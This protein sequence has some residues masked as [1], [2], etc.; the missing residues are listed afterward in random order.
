MIG[1]ETESRVDSF[2]SACERVWAEE[3]IVNGPKYMSRAPARLDVM[4]G[5]A[6]Y[7]GSL[8]LQCALPVE[9][10]VGIAP[11]GDQK[12]SITSIG[13]SNNGA[14][15]QSIWPL[16]ALYTSAGKLASPESFAAYFETSGS[17]W[18]RHVAGVF[19]TLLEAGVVPHFAGGAS[20][21][22]QSDI[23][24]G[25]G[26]GASAAIAVASGWALV[27]LTGRT[28]APIELARLCQRA[29]TF[30]AGVPCGITDK[31]VALLA[32]SGTLLQMRCQPHE[33]LGHMPLCPG[34]A[35][36]GIDSR[37]QAE[38]RCHR[39]IETRVASFMGLRIIESVLR[40]NPSGVDITGGYLAN[41]TPTEYVERLRDRIPTKM[42]G[43]DFLERYGHINDPAT[44]V[45]PDTMYKVRSRTEH[46]IYENDRVHRFAERISRA[47]RTQDRGPLIEAGEL[48]YASH[49]SYSQRCGMGSIDTDTLVN[50][51]REQGVDRGIYGAKI[52]SAG[53]GGSVAVLLADTPT[54]HEAVEQACHAYAMKTGREP[55]IFTGSADGAAGEAPRVLD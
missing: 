41:I 2:A 17:P 22:I 1:T 3:P 19:Y 36:V 20:I 53:C 45:A 54:A 55:E 32:E 6:D 31:A 38:K 46:H 50:L 49:W 33:V 9:A 44:R 12:V 26:I 37:A 24:S 30:V 25:A 11:R 23:P 10:R 52:T 21:V 47:A 5:V 14:G 42:K 48:M 8:V 34:T 27:A 43:R 28:I 29:E 15:A 18:A 4:G 16:S 39:F 35:F 7:T 40:G 51:L 13:W